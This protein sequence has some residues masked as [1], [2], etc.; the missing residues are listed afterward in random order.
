MALQHPDV[1]PLSRRVDLMC[2]KYF[3][4]TAA[5]GTDYS[6]PITPGLEDEASETTAVIKQYEETI[7]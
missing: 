6:P 5:K 4:K 1:F 2:S 7:K 3:E